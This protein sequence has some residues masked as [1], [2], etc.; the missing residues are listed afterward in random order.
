MFLENV[1]EL[2]RRSSKKVL[3]ICDFQESE[4]CTEKVMREYCSVQN[5]MDRNNGKYICPSCS[6]MMRCGRNN[7]S[8]K[9]KNLDDHLMDV[10]DS[11]EKAYL[12]GWIASDGSLHENGCVYIAINTCDVG[13]L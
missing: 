3:V 7:P 10:I 6:M 12:L 1:S 8:C 5:T 13:V 9:Y 11:E 2:S 4:K